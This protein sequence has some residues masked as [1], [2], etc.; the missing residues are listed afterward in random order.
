MNLYEVAQ[1]ITQRLTRIFLPDEQGHRPV[2][3]MT[4]K[5]ADDPNW[6][7]HL[8]FFEYF[9]GDNGAGIGAS[10]QTGWTGMVAA[11]MHFFATHS[12]ESLLVERIRQTPAREAALPVVHAPAA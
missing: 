7:D 5:F 9:H 3:G 1:D 12:A 2:Y 6:R 11:L 8:L 10:H 4:K